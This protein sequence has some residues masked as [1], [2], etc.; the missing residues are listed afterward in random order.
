MYC[1]L[2]H[3]ADPDLNMSRF[4]RVEL[5]TDV[6]DAITLQRTRGRI[7][8]RGQNRF[9]SFPSTA[10]AEAAA[11]KL[12]SVE[13]AAWL[14]QRQIVRCQCCSRPSGCFRGQAPTPWT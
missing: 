1:H 10:S 9:V 13:G 3:R 12:V 11:T 2:L 8:S 14:L 6:F 7:D 4:H 5:S